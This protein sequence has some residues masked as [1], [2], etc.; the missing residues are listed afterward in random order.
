MTNRD[1]DN[2]DAFGKQITEFLPALRRYALSL[3]RNPSSADDLVQDCVTRALTKQDLFKQGTNLRAWLFSIMHNLYISGVR[4]ISVRR[5]VS[6]PEPALNAMSTPARQ[7]DTV[8]LKSVSSRLNK[9]PEQ[10]R[11]ILSAIAIYGFSYEEAAQML[12]IPV[13]TVKSRC[14]RARATIRSQFNWQNMNDAQNVAE[15]VQ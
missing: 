14:N 3:T 13:G 7:T 11:V 5:E 9:L 8:L 4:K 2:A 1:D 15:S 6:D 12:D 10:Q